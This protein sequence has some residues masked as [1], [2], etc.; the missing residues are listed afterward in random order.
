MASEP[1][2]EFAAQLSDQIGVL[3]AGIASAS[4]EAFFYRGLDFGHAFE[5]YTYYSVVNDEAL[6][7]LYAG[8]DH[9]ARIPK[10]SSDLS[11]LVARHWFGEE[12]ARQGV[13]GKLM[14]VPLRRRLRALLGWKLFHTPHQKRR[15]GEI[16]LFASS[17]R[18]A[19][20]LMPIADALKGR[21]AFLVSAL[22]TDL[23]AELAAAGYEFATYG[24]AGP[25]LRR[26]TGM[27]TRHAPAITLVADEIDEALRRLAP[28]AILLSEGN[29]PDDEIINRVGQRLE[30]P[31]ACLQQGWSPL[32][33]S[34]FRNMSYASML[35]WGDGFAE[36]LR[37]HNPRQ[38]F[39][40]VGSHVLFSH[41]E[42]PG[43]QRRGI[44][45]FSM[46]VGLWMSAQDEK[47][48]LSLAPH[49]AR[50]MP[51]QTIL[52]RPHPIFPFDEETLRSLAL[53]NIE[54]AAGPAI[55]LA[56]VLA[57][58]RAAVSIYSSTILESIA[59]G[60]IPVVFNMTTMPHYLPDVAAAGAGVE[61]K[62][63]EAAAQTL[64][65]FLSDPEAARAFEPA[66]QTF[67]RKYF[68]ARGAEAIANIVA[69]LERLMASKS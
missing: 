49:I 36:I 26:M 28:S 17:L 34:G 13:S 24:P 7:G 30:I 14:L 38:S 33:H 8:K 66:M 23:C 48:L 3:V 20:Y 46:G 52:V 58:S 22:A 54:I 18:F 61:V 6:H 11:H 60:T 62:T 56:E 10:F 64:V 45:V 63:F 1:S 9:T 25:A 5:L 40:A 19:R 16:L 47:L 31:V 32:V 29:A 68:A 43:W 15:A 21:C 37:P 50:A 44:A 67:E 59:A 69:E 42:T 55:S 2:Y 4:P 41:F 35:V 57:R 51:G 39:V 12:K 53:P 27:L 65:R